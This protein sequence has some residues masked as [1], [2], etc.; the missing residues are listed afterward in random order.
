[1]SS[2]FTPFRELGDN[3]MAAEYYGRHVRDRL[4]LQS[5][6]E[7]FDL[8]SSQEVGGGVAI[9]NDLAEGLLFLANTAFKHSDYHTAESYC[10]K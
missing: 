3:D 5:S 8:L 7:G 1:V 9:D 10:L 2:P 4:A 6:A